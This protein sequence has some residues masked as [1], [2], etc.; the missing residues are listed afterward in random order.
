MC[1]KRIFDRVDNDVDY[2]NAI[3]EWVARAQLAFE[4]KLW[5]INSLAVI[6][7]PQE[8]FKVKTNH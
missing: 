7:S 8:H 2:N 4:V 3:I 1:D 5:F 6:K